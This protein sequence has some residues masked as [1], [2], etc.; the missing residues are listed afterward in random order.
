LELAAEKLAGTTT[1]F[2]GGMTVTSAAERRL[3]G[4]LTLPWPTRAETTVPDVPARIAPWTVVVSGVMPV[5]LTTGWLVA[6]TVQPASY[7]PMRQT[8]SVLSGYG[9]TDR[10][11]V[12]AALYTVGVA[13]FVTAAGMRGVGAA[14]RIGLLVAGAAAVGV[15]FFP[16]PAHGTSRE[17]A[18]C[19]AVGALTIAAWPALAARRES[20]LA[21]V[22]VRRSLVAIVVSI[23]LLVWTAVETRNG[24]LLG[25]AERVS[26]GVQV[27]WPFVVALILLR[28]QSD[29]ADESAQLSVEA[30]GTRS[31]AH[32]SG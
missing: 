9:G 11:I 22:G 31:V 3:L 25:L 10:W 2:S 5:L 32:Q 29:P 26:S 24:P 14:A 27:T 1:Q 19:T 16:E 6:G 21:V 28:T 13:Y 17:H 30:H 12:T 20:V 23:G 4:R 18:V 7:S 8:V 15:A